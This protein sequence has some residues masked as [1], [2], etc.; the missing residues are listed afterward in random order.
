[1]ASVFE[2]F[3]NVNF[4]NRY[5]L[6]QKLFSYLQENYSDYISEVG[7]SVLGQPVYQF[8]IGNGPVNILAW[9][10]MHGNESTATLAMLDLLYSMDKN[11]ELKDR[12]FSKITLDFI[13]MLNPD[14]SEKWTRRN[15][16]DID[17]NRDFL[18]ESSPEIKILKNIAK[19]KKYDYALNLHDQRTIFTTDGVHPATLSFL[20]PSFDQDRTL[21]ENRKKSMAIIAHIYSDLKNKIPNRIGRY[22][23]EFYPTSTGDNFMLA[24]IP[25]V[26]FEGGHSEDDYLRKETR[27]YY[28]LALYDALAAMSIIPG[29]TL[30]YET[31]FDIPENQQTHYDVIYRNVKLNTDFDCVLD[32]AVQY[33]EVINEGADEIS[34]VPI[35]AEVGDIGKKKAWKE[36]DATGKKFISDKKY[37][38]LDEE[39]NF[40]LG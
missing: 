35:V 36:I 2:Y 37:P 15:A 29:Q 34:F 21:N 24:G 1:M 13:F 11:T 18:K 30:G 32:V 8:S 31:Y 38:K 33:K 20:A 3:T 19:E 14:G 40:S 7:K 16:L 17:M 22:T 6:P 9:S 39:V 4:S 5:I 25:T 26:L 23:D 28:T 27:K 12:L 10:Q